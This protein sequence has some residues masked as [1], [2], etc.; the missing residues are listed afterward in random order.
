MKLKHK[1]KE[2]VKVVLKDLH[3][4]IDSLREK[5]EKLCE[6]TEGCHGETKASAE[7]SES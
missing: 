3:K 1:T 7:K 6:S 2:E 5:V 4:K